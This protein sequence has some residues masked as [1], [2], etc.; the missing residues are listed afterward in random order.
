[1]VK[2]IKLNPDTMTIYSHANTVLEYE[3]ISI[4]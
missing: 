2:R 1:M 3:L 4:K